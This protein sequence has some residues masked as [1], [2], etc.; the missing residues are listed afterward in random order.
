M[1]YFECC[2]W[3]V[4]PKR[5]PGCSSKCPDYAQARA[6]FEADKAKNESRTITRNYT[7]EHIRKAKDEVAKRK[8][9]HRPYSK[10]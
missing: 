10:F 5:Y 2:H 7:I 3:C 4:P 9:D 1:N 6:K 8:R